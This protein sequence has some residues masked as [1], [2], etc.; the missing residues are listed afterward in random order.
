L[1]VVE[2]SL[3]FALEL[4]SVLLLSSETTLNLSQLHLGC[5]T[6]GTLPLP[7]HRFL[8]TSEQSEGNSGG[9]QS[10]YLQPVSQSV[11][12]FVYNQSVSNRY[13]LS[14]MCTQ[15]TQPTQHSAPQHTQHQHL[16]IL[17]TSTSAPLSTHLHCCLEL[18][19]KPVLDTR[20]SP[21]LLLRRTQ[22]HSV[23]IQLPLQLCNLSHQ[24]LSATSCACQ[25]LSATSCQALSATSC[26]CQTLSATSCHTRLSQPQAVTPDTLS[27][28][29]SRQT[30]SATSCACQTLSATSCACHV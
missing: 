23:F 4:Y 21:Q 12:Q 1:H 18:F 17:S 22:L 25:T 14:H 5:L 19:L 10:T 20:R 24:T 8:H 27:H 2:Q 6:C 30:L 26:A 3:Q 28:K 15:H 9:A 7:H 11:S 29:L 16:S 13:A